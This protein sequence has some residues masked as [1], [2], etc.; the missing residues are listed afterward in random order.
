MTIQ[1]SKSL[2]SAFRR[3]SG[4]AVGRVT[5]PIL[6][7]VRLEATA[8][9]L[10]ISA[11]NLDA[12]ATASCDF[13]GDLAPICVRASALAAL[14][15][16]AS[17]VIEMEVMPNTKLK[18]KGAGLGMLETLPAADF[19]KW[20]EIGIAIGLSTTELAECLR[21]VSWC[22][23]SDDT[24]RPLLNCVGV[25][26]GARFIRCSATTGRQLA[27]MDRPTIAADSEFV[28]PASQCAILANALEMDACDLHLTPNFITA[29]SP[30]L[31]VSVKLADLGKFYDIT[32]VYAQDR[33]EVGTLDVAQFVEALG[34]VLAI[35]DNTMLGS[36]ARTKLE[37]TESGMEI[38][39]H[40]PN[41]F[42]TVIPG[43]FQ[44]FSMY[45]NPNL[46][47]DS[48]KVIGGPAVRL[49][50]FANGMAFVAG[51]LIVAT[52]RLNNVGEKA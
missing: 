52:S 35:A 27:Y 43:T 10:S 14:I 18:V 16:N 4:L 39:Y 24:S 26:T 40:G 47:H 34:T 48:L 30:A 5:I 32:R 13:E 3:V 36:F 6:A 12:F 22:A 51:D 44:P 49:D 2:F 21:A 29:R 33:A 1:D 42:N 19:P 45:F 41:E 25:H 8:G 31:Q 20:P 15:S 9:I 17:G 23:G 7:C 37:A 46:L 11:S 28:M 50:S 38:S